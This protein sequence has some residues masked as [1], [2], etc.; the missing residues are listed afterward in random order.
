MKTNF[1]KGPDLTKQMEK[2]AGKVEEMKTHQEQEKE[3]IESPSIGEV[4]EKEEV[5]TLSVEEGGGLF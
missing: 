2:Q 1:C 4:E 5:K 3:A